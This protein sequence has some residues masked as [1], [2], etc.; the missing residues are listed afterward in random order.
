M[1][2][3]ARKHGF[4]APQPQ[5]ASSPTALAEAVEHLKAVNAAVDAW[6]E[7]HESVE[8]TD[9]AKAE[10]EALDYIAARDRVFATPAMTAADLAAKVAT[11]WEVCHDIDWHPAREDHRE[12]IAKG[13]EA[14]HALL[15]CYLDAQALAGVVPDVAPASPDLEALIH[16]L[17]EASAKI[18]PLFGMNDEVAAQ[19]DG[20]TI[21]EQDRAALTKAGT[22]FKRAL[23]ALI[24]YRPTTAAMMARKSAALFA[25]EHIAFSADA[26][27]LGEVYRRDAEHL[28]RHE[29][30]RSVISGVP[31][32]S[33]S[34]DALASRLVAAIDHFDTADAEGDAFDAEG[35]AVPRHH[36]AA[37]AM[38]TAAEALRSA[39]LDSV[40]GFALRLLK[41]ASD[42]D[43][44]VH[45]GDVQQ[46]EAAARAITATVRDALRFLSPSVS[47]EV[48]TYFMGPQA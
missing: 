4:V 1:S 20:R 46:R 24:D 38:H 3:P 17:A 5:P 18:T 6:Y 21:T 19:R 15:T 47:S 30:L 34:S 23:E 2:A 40:N 13:D 33:A 41:V 35:N 27:D 43:R 22:E 8:P 31:L 16:A 26:Y 48:I 32:A 29:A 14:D 12:I 36:D 7:A 9:E 45:G 37:D 42:A 44:A 39:P 25:D 10:L 11:L 28:A